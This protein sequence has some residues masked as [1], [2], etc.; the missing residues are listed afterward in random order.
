MKKLFILLFTFSLLLSCGDNRTVKYEHK[1]LVISD[2]REKVVDGDTRYVFYF[3]EH[4]SEYMDYEL[5]SSYEIG[6]TVCFE[7]EENWF[8]WCVVSDCE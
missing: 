6:D 8:F 7:R 3:I 4:R 2:K 5:Y 1:Q